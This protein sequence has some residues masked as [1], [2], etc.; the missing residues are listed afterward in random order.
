MNRFWKTSSLVLSALL[1]M[2]ACAQSGGQTS[3]TEAATATYKPSH[4][5]FINPERGFYAY[6]DFH[7]E[8]ES[9][10][11]DAAA[12]V[13]EKAKAGYQLSLIHQSYFLPDYRDAEH[14]PADFLNAGRK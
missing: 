5:D 10:A 4:A 13:Q 6:S 12:L 8:K 2:S 9:S 1:L 14:L 7:T 11:L 3:T